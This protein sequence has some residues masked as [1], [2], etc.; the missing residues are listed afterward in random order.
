[1]RQFI[2]G[3]TSN[4]I[5]D[6]DPNYSDFTTLPEG[7][8]GIYVKAAGIDKLVDVTNTDVDAIKDIATLVLGRSSA[9]GGPVVLPIYRNHFSYSLLTP[10]A[11]VK[12]DSRINNIL[13]P[14]VVGEYGVIVA[15]KG[16]GFNE[17]NKFYCSVYI[18]DV[19]TTA[20]VLTSLLAAE[21]NKK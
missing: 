15:K 12:A 3:S 19:T 17:K 21:I 18:K 14:T 8:V 10:S 20:A 13:A 4:A 2:L 16:I 6:G 9:K 11:P 5:D 1:M 7:E